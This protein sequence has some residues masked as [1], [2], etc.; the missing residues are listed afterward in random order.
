[1]GFVDTTGTCTPGRGEA[2]RIEEEAHHCTKA[3]GASWQLASNSAIGSRKALERGCGCLRQMED[4]RFSE[5]SHYEEF[6]HQ[7]NGVRRG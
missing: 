3:G 4:L 1:M 5:E 7:A 6:R 2:G